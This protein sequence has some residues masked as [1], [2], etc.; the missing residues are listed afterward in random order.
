MNTRMAA[1]VLLSV[2]A[3]SLV[4]CGSN[5][6][7]DEPGVPKVLTPVPP[8]AQAT[9]PPIRAM[10]PGAVEVINRDL[11]GSGEYRF[12]PSEF[13]FEVGQE[14][15]FALVAEAEFHTFTVDELGIDVSMEAGETVFYTFTFD[16]PGTYRLTCVPHEALGMTGE[17]V[18]K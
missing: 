13:S 4:A 7:V 12:E 16:K 8:T 2:F 18:V 17:I 5:G 6:N 1:L 9:K 15:T 14:V 3:A 11:K 10:P